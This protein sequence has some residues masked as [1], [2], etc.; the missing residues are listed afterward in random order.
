MSVLKPNSRYIDTYGK[1]FVIVQEQDGMVWYTHKD[2]VYS[3]RTKAF[4]ERFTLI[5]NQS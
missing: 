4:L 1:E 2:V 3:C 5:D